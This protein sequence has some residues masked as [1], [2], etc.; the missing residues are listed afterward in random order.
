MRATGQYSSIMNLIG[1]LY[2]AEGWRVFYRGYLAN[3]L[4]GKHKQENILTFNYRF[5]F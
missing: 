5:D 2:R 4:G 3:S 1:K